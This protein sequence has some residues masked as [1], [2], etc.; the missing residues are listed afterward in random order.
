MS[1]SRLLFYCQHSVGLGHLVRSLNLAT[2]LAESFDVTFLNGGPWPPDVAPPPGVA[3]VNLPP[4]GHDADYAL[5]SR[6]PKLTVEQACEL[7]RRT[8]LST[9]EEI[10]PDVVLVELFPFGRKKFAFELLPL[11]QAVRAAPGTRPLVVSSLRDILVGSRRDQQGHDDRACRTANEYFDAILVH[12]DARFAAIEESFSPSMPLVPPVHYT[13]FVRTPTPDR[14]V[15]GGLRRVLVSAGGGMV[16]EPLFTAAVA[17]QP[18]LFAEHGLRMT[19]VTGPFL[20]EQDRANLHRA[21]TGVPGLEVVRFLSDLAGEMAASTVSVSQA[22]YNTTMDL[23]GCGTPAVVVPYGEGREDEQAERARRLETMG[24]LRVL[25]A[26]KLSGDALAD[27]VVDALGW[28][29]LPLPLDLDGR[30]A[31]RRLLHS[32]TGAPVAEAVA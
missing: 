7:R 14:P 31:T 1:R 9:Y 27:A 4:L 23:L 25:A 10:R 11:L 5:V 22:G 24:A 8:V 18:R 28:Q 6:D 17:A 30:E 29:P 21:A 20:P 32:L 12:A 19:L 15:P 2:G 3:M 26:D 13:G 16:G